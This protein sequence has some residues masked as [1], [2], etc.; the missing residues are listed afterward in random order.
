[1][2]AVHNV[3]QKVWFVYTHLCMCVRV[4]VHTHDVCVC[5]CISTFALRVYYSVLCIRDGTTTTH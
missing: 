2:C 4:C 5:A 1:M 3:L